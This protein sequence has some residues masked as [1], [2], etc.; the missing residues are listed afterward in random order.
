MAST[1][2]LP[3]VGSATLLNYFNAQ[4]TA[5]SVQHT[6]HASSNASASTTA[7]QSPPWNTP[8]KAND[9]ARDAQ[10]LTTT[11]FINLDASTLTGGTSSSDKTQADNERLFALYKGVNQLYYLASMAQRASTTPGQLA[12][13]DTRF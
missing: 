2:S 6:A 9:P 4:I 13:Y 11:N 7:A 10:V 5:Q 8:G 12:G 1:G 3:S